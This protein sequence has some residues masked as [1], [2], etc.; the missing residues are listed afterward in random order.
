MP[1]QGVTCHRQI[2]ILQLCLQGS[3]SACYGE[4]VK[5]RKRNE[6]RNL[7]A[8][9]DWPKPRLSYDFS[10]GHN[11][12]A[13]YSITRFSVHADDITARG[14]FLLTQKGGHLWPYFPPRI[15]LDSNVVLFLHV[16]CFGRSGAHHFVIRRGFFVSS[17][18]LFLVQKG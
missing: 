5:K 17:G 2:H 10:L 8:A 13:A 15:S 3:Q 1:G 12:H 11:L 4:Y 18:S 16:L 9:Y 7:I 14:I 6:P